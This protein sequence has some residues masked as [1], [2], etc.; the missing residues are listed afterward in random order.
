MNERK[1]VYK[2]PAGDTTLEWYSKA[3]VEMKKRPTTDPTS[4]HYQ[5]AIHGFYATSHFW[6]GAKPLPKPTEQKEFWKQCQH[7]SWF[8]LPWHRMYLAYFEQ[9]V[10]QTIVDLRGPKGWSL[11]FWDYSDSSNPNALT[12]PPAF[13]NPNN[14][15]NGLWITGR[16]SNTV[17]ARYV[18]LGALNTIPYAGDGRTSPLGFGG[19]VTS[20]SHNGATHGE[21]E[22]APHDLVHVAIG[23][24]MG[25]PRTA[26]L[27]PVFWLHHANIDRLW[28][29]WLDKGNRINPTQSSWLDFKFSFHD[30]NG[31]IAQMTC[32]S[33][34]DTRKVLSGYTY[35]GVA[36]G[37]PVLKRADITGAMDFSMPLEV[38]AATNKRLIL[39][40]AKAIV[41]LKLSPSRLK[42][43]NFTAINEAIAKPPVTILHFENITGKGVPPIYDVYLNVPESDGNKE[44][45]YAGS[46]SFFG[47][48]EASIPSLHQSGSGQHYALD[49]SELM[50]KLRSLPNWDESKLDVSIEPTRELD[51]GAS[52]T[53]GRISLYSE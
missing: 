25:D 36:P 34:E 13:T 52:V 39:N 24:A 29:V 11:P 28:Q 21:L 19:P 41:N 31:K 44:S 18:R 43:S 42:V 15:T 1:N 8:F 10:A 16:A 20:F 50:N 38:V 3:V 35:R 53:I 49:V 30:K 48:E 2:L 14:A 47:V 17:P 9:I 7:G 45:Y 6:K 22:S 51:K 27:D 12:M 37:T 33:V 23:G 40:S 46:L 4:W 5:A 32:S 26:A